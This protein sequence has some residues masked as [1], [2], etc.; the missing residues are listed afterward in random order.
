MSARTT[1]DLREAVEEASRELAGAPLALAADPA[2]ASASPA[3]AAAL[4]IARLER[5]L[6]SSRLETVAAA[7]ALAK[8][9]ALR[10]EAETDAFLNEMRGVAGSS[11]ADTASHAD[12]ARR[13]ATDPELGDVMATL[14]GLPP[15][16]RNSA[17]RAWA[18]FALAH[19]QGWVP[20]SDGK[21]LAENRDVHPSVSRLLAAVTARDALRVWHEGYA[22]DDVPT[23]KVRPDFLLTHVRD[24]GASTVGAAVMVEVKLPGCIDDAV[25]QLCAYLRRRVYKLCCERCARGE[26]FSDVFALGAAT[27]GCGVVLVRMLSGAPA[28]GASFKGAKPCPSIATAPL[29]LLADWDFRAPVNFSLRAP[30]AGVVA[31]A[32]LCGSAAALG[33][34]APLTLLRAD[35]VWAASGSDIPGG[36]G[37]AGDEGGSETRRVAVAVDL[38]LGERLGSGGTSDAYEWAGDASAVIKVARCLTEEIALGF[39]AEE[40]AL[41]ALRSV[42]SVGLVPELVGAGARTPDGRVGEHGGGAWPLLVLR[43]RGV[44][45]AAWVAKRVAE[46]PRDRGRAAA[47]RS[48]ASAV[49]ARV[50]RA[51]EAAAA[52]GLVHC[53]VR[54]A[55][56]VIVGDAAVLVDWGCS[57]ERGSEARGRGVAAFADARVF[58]PSTTTFAARPSQDVVGALLTWAAIACDVGCAAPWL[59]P[60]AASPAGGSTVADML[61]RREAWLAAAAARGDIPALLVATLA[62]AATIGAGA[63]AGASAGALSDIFVRAHAAIA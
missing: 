36:A 52:A 39:A 11:S 60:R 57:C 62:A 23:A 16:A 28:P 26:P 10:I 58:A 22:E 43:P 3:Q 38:A 9:R 21:D 29:P 24:A 18:E 7:A 42:A 25:V 30:P 32:H 33:S 1:S 44:Q 4:A 46:S 6:A 63:G 45:L 56:I 61:A 12:V 40:R 5:L 51:L 47:R 8:E 27:D 34:C 37:G 49:V 35:I 59:A 55:N 53:D 13:G 41:T 31:L 54:P 14:E 17:S 50:L 20:P 19:E 15:P 48:A 2:I